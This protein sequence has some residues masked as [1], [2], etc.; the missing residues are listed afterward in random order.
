MER[1]G[2]WSGLAASLREAVRRAQRAGAPVTALTI[3]PEWSPAISRLQLDDASSVLIGLP[4][5]Q[6]RRS[7][8]GEAF[9]A[10]A[11]PV[12]QASA[13]PMEP[14]TREDVQDYLKSW[15]SLSRQRP[16]GR[17]LP[18]LPE[19]SGQLAGV[20]FL[21]EAAGIR[22]SREPAALLQADGI[23]VPSLALHIA[24]RMEGLRPA[25]LLAGDELVRMGERSLGTDAGYR[26][27]PYFYRR[28][29]DGGILRVSIET[30]LDGQVPDGELRG[31]AVLIGSS[32][33]NWGERL[34]TPAG[35][36]MGAAE[37]VARHAAAL[38]QGD[39]N[40]APEW[41]VYAPW[42]A[43]AVVTLYL[44]LLLPRLGL[45]AG[46]VLSLLVAVALINVQLGMPVARMAHLELAMPLMAL[47]FGHGL[48]GI[49][50]YYDYRGQAWSTE[51]SESNRLLGEALQKQ[52]ELDAAFARLRRCEPGPKVLSSLYDLALDLERR[53]QFAN[54]QSVLRY[55]DRHSPGF[56]DVAERMK[57]V[58]DLERKT[59]LGGKKTHSGTLIVPD[60]D[61]QKPMLGRYQIIKEL[62][63]GAMGVVYL[64]K[65]PKIGRTVAIK[66]MALSQEFEGDT[67]KQV[68]E[69]FFQEAETAGRLRHPG[70]V[71]IYDVGEEDDLAYIAMDYLEGKGLQHYT[72][73][74]ELLPVTTVCDI[75]AQVADAL[76]YA[77]E[78]NVVHRDI[79]PANMIYMPE[80][81]RIVLTDFGVACLTDTS[82]T[83]TGTILGTPSYMSP[84]QV[85]GKKVDGRSD[86]FSL[87]VTM[88][89]LLRGELPF[90]GE[91]LA[92]LLYKIANENAPS[93]TRQR[94]DLPPCIGRIVKRA[95]AKKAQD[96]FQSGIEMATAIRRCRREVAA[97]TENRSK[98]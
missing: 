4:W 69:R 8:P 98:G 36:E 44:V 17:L 35:V 33:P 78:R 43:L 95:V 32:S 86:L 13:V 41:G 12:I 16:Q 81:R 26:Y 49:K 91:S 80:T 67:L 42:A 53:R 14:I 18:I 60:D 63:R 31:K 3:P 25:D 57:K 37:V 50:Q 9:D 5:H 24:L 47:L 6:A 96:R 19:R 51:L 15:L 72:E 83:K 90:E 22:A 94:P 48:L 2:D 7:S 93:V 85:L 10:W 82:R 64:G 77:H 87:G 39:I 45:T 21:P 79:K 74:S 66:T 27:R 97:K 92:A 34:R 30:L 58:A 38:M 55:I 46:L 28:A 23:L 62:G 59:A 76:E 65:D 68:T 73:P 75:I 89:Q 54:A 40:V 88:Y 71:T 20:G 70:I 61:M 56:R 52:G 1:F 29:D 84:E 11:P